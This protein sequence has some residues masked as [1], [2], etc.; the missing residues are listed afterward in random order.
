MAVDSRLTQE[1]RSLLLEQRVATLG[2]LNQDG[3]P[4]VSMVPFAV[5]RPHRCIVIHVS[6]LAAHTANLLA[7]PTLSLLV[8]RPEL[9]GAPVHALPR[10]TLQGSAEVLVRE[11]AAWNACRTAYLARFPEAEPMTALAD[12][13][14]VAIHLQGARQIAG[15][16]SARS[17]G[18]DELMQLLADGKEAKL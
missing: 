13:L 10:A 5:A 16:G 1:L 3:T 14:F 8:M 15:F 18:P 2:T 9:P 6:G 11:S 12:F 7:R 4:M 17:V